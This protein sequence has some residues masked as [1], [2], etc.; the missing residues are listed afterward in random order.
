MSASSLFL[1]LLSNQF[2][3]STQN[4]AGSV[5]YIIDVIWHNGIKMKGKCMVAFK[6][7]N[8]KKNHGSYAS[9]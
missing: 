6:V 2:S 4:V 7:L 5:A 3:T 1:F 8:L 9:I